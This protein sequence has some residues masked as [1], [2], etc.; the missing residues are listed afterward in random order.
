VPYDGLTGFKDLVNSTVE[1]EFP[2][3]EPVLEF[4]SGLPIFYEG[5]EASTKFT[6][7]ALRD[8]AAYIT[9]ETSDASALANDQFIATTLMIFDTLSGQATPP[10]DATEQA[11]TLIRP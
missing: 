8:Q 2:D 10:S 7:L 11:P 3:A 9:M 4:L 6:M 5:E 1:M